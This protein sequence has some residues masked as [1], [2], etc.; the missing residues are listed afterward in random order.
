MNEKL[1]IKDIAKR[2]NV[3][4]T[5]VSF[6]INGKAAD[7]SISKKVTA[8]VLKL[9]GELGFRP[10]SFAKGLRTGKSNTIGFLV[11]DISMTFFSGIARFLEEKAALNGYKIL[12]AS[13]GIEKNKFRDLIGVFTERRV[14]GYVIAAAEGV[15]EEI[16]ELIRSEVPVV[17]FDRYL[18]N[19]AADYVLVDNFGSTFQA[20]SHLIGN[21]YR[22]CAFITIETQQQQM[23]DR[24]EG[25]RKAILSNGGQ[26][27]ILK[28]KYTG[29]GSAVASIQ[30]FLD[31]SGSIDAVIFSTNYITMEGLRA[32]RNA[33]DE[34]RNDLALISF[35]DF[36]L[37]EFISPPITAIEQPLDKIAAHIMKLLLSRINHASSSDAC[38]TIN[39]PCSLNVRASSVPRP[40]IYIKK[41]LGREHFKIR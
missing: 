24:L 7:K 32:L 14:D 5:T 2:L 18:P 16:K 22:N 23:M 34:I 20:T 21:G 6:V 12:F 19:I 35:D 38:C 31:C 3:S 1:S 27:H 39:I 33:K 10:N 29:P 40:G 13:T 30:D 4:T 15:E 28:L 17:L 36:E 8:K 37:L 9:V 41:A 26:E 11:D 25:Y